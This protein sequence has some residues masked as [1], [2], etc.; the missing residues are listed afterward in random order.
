MNAVSSMLGT[1]Q[2]GEEDDGDGDSDDDD[3]NHNNHNNNEGDD[4][5]DNDDISI[6]GDQIEEWCLR[7]ERRRAEARVLPSHDDPTARLQA[8]G[9]KKEAKKQ[10]PRSPGES[11]AAPGGVHIG[12]MRSF[13]L[14]FCFLS[15]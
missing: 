8:K 6:D 9:A 10:T 15:P 7:R 14:S 3:N 5:S 11:T 4:D 2:Q 13:C 12:A 1:K